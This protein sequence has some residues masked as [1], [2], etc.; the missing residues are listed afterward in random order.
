MRLKHYCL[1]QC[2][3][4]ALLHS[5]DDVAVNRSFSLFRWKKLRR[6]KKSLGKSAATTSP[7]GKM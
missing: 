4:K 1:D 6:R 7:I 3:T 2:A 5:F